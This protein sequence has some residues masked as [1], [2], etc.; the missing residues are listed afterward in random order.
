MRLKWLPG[1]RKPKIILRKPKLRLPSEI[2]TSLLLQ[3]ALIF[4]FCI[5]M[6]LIFDIVREP[7][8]LGSRFGIPVLID[9]RLD[10][11]FIIE[12]IVA[13]II[14]FVGFVGF[15]VIFYSTRYFYEP[16]YAR[17]LLLIGVVAVISA[18]FVLLYMMIPKLPQG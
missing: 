6:G 15:V 2:P 17:T 16:S 13:S 8:P 9:E 7:L 3:I 1:I 5:Y 12:G 14:M 18:Y 10:A 4:I 11:Q